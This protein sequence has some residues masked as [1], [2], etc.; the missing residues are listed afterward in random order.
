MVTCLSKICCLRLIEHNVIRIIFTLIKQSNRSQP[1]MEVLK[2]ALNILEN[3]S[4]TPET[5]QYVF[6][7]PEGVEILVESLQSYRENEQIFACAASVLVVMARGGQD[8]IANAR[9]MRQ[10]PNVLKRI[11]MVHAFAER[12]HAKEATGSGTAAK[13]S[14]ATKTAPKTGAS[15]RGVAATKKQKERERERERA[16]RALAS[17]TELVERLEGRC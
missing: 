15:V 16:S 2:H 3:L 7:D 1:H 11:K 14:K 10:L 6:A 4:R 13:P 17:L 12:R 9:Y 5:S 8:G